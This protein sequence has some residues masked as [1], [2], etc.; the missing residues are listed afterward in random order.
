MKFI[1]CFFALKVL[2]LLLVTTTRNSAFANQSAFIIEP[3]IGY[4]QESL[5]LTDLSNNLTKYTLNGPMGS[6]KI[7]VQSSAGVSLALSAEQSSGQIMTEP[8]MT[9]KPKFSH[10]IA[11][12]QIGVSALNTMKIYLG[13]SPYNKLELKNQ[14]SFTGFTLSG[15]TYQAGVVFFPFRYVGLGVQYNVNQYQQVSGVD[16]TSGKEVDTYFDQID[17]QDLSISLSIML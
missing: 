9:D 10:T 15:H 13:Y 4:K 17:S 8:E 16:Y 1:K 14:G 3:G 12:F 6:L 11:G 7:G 5:K 2:L